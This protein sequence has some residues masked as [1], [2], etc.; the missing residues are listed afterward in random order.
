MNRTANGPRIRFGE[1]VEAPPT[2]SPVAVDETTVYAMGESWLSRN[3][4]WV[5][6]GALGVTATAGAAIGGSAAYANR[7]KTGAI[8][9]YSVLGGVLGGALGT[10]VAVVLA[11]F[12]R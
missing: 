3:R 9:G 6:L 8:V 4:Y 5:M 2:L 12:V 11:R 10:G 1:P 7:K